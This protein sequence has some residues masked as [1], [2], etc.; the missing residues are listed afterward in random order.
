M[1]DKLADN[2]S[3]LKIILNGLHLDKELQQEVIQLMA[4]DSDIKR[5]IR[6]GKRQIWSQLFVL[7]FILLASIAGI[8]FRTFDILSETLIPAALTMTTVAGILCLIIFHLSQYWTAFRGLFKGYPE[9][10]RY[11]GFILSGRSP[12]GPLG[13]WSMFISGLSDS[14][15]LVPA[16]MVFKGDTKFIYCGQPY[17]KIEFI[18]SILISTSR[19]IK[20][21]YKIF[22]KN[23]SKETFIHKFEGR[24]PFDFKVKELTQ[25]KNVFGI[26]FLSKFL[27]ELIKIKDGKVDVDKKF[28][29]DFSDDL[30]DNEKIEFAKECIKLSCDPSTTFFGELPT[31]N[32]NI[33]KIKVENIFTLKDMKDGRIPT[34][35]KLSENQ[36][37]I[38]FKRFI[39]LPVKYETQIDGKIKPLVDRNLIL[40]SLPES[41]EHSKIYAMGGAEHNLSLLHIINLHRE[42]NMNDRTFGIAE[43]AFDQPEYSKISKCNIKFRVGA[44]HFVYGINS[45]VRNRILDNIEANNSNEAEVFKLEINQHE[46]YCFYGYS[47]PMTRI[48]FL[49]FLYEYENKES[50]YIPGINSP[51]CYSVLIDTPKLYGSKFLKEW[52]ANDCMNNPLCDNC[53]NLLKDGN[54]KLI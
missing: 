48:A 50:K 38:P 16:T 4:I 24:P 44:S 13:L 28:Y 43:N 23:F 46:I 33:I 11:C 54:I 20:E 53:K 49:K 51:K 29:F 17:Y 27:Y 12:K 35:K 40:P 7:G 47:A 25:S 3:V 37:L 18:D 30:K 41:S 9:F 8:T 10:L 14:H 39:A 22:L 15:A 32:A 42:L 5:L 1:S 2:S 52:D 45:I 26:F 31:N 21:K 36:T 34:K 6:T 19:D